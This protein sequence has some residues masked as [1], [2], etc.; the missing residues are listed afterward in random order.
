MTA[1]I[2]HCVLLF[3]EDWG[4][5]RSDEIA[6]QDWLR[7]PNRSSP[8]HLT[9]LEN[10]VK[11][12][13]QGRVSRTQSSGKSLCLDN[14]IARLGEWVHIPTS[15][16]CSSNYQSQPVIWGSSTS[17]STE[18]RSVCLKGRIECKYLGIDPT[19]TYDIISEIIIMTWQQGRIIIRVDLVHKGALK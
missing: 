13:T 2:S 6:R 5:P 12:P 8:A 15:H 18:L 7:W 10:W 16:G 9:L 17:T 4:A 19:N 3:C 1:G 11:I 14:A